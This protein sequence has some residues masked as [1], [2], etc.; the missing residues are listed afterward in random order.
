MR[1]P[2]RLAE[3]HRGKGGVMLGQLDPRLQLDL[4]QVTR[5]RFFDAR[6]EQST[7]DPLTLPCW[8]DREFPEIKRVTFR[9][10]KH[11]AEQRV[12]AAAGLAFA[13]PLQRW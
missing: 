10:Q 4:G 2:S 11:T 8:P 3:S 7:A 5:A 13:L 6:L 9:F 12:C 1:G